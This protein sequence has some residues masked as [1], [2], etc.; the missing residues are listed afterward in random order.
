MRLGMYTSALSFLF[1]TTFT[2]ALSCHYYMSNNVT[3]YY[4]SYV[5]SVRQKLYNQIHA[6][7][8]Q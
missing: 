5:D 3:R 4:L 2:A 8:I 6:T 7:L 1:H